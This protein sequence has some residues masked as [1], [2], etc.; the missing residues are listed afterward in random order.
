M[1][2]NPYWLLLI[3]SVIIASFSQILLK[4]SALK[5]YSSIL[6]EYLNLKVILGYGM[7]VLSTIL[8]VFAFKGM[9]YKNGPI[10]ESIGYLLV[11]FLSAWLLKE[12]M[13][14]KKIIGNALILIG[15][16]VFYL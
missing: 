9:D 16:V 12:K 1:K 8:T 11:M 2:I 3:A 7:M 14:R 15:I 4:K 5:K 10:I 6:Q 13:T